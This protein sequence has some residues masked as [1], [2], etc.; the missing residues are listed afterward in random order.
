MFA[1]KIGGVHPLIP[2]SLCSAWPS[3]LLV[4]G[5]DRPGQSET[6]LA[7]RSAAHAKL[8]GQYKKKQQ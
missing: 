5:P 1:L 7:V 8:P 6:E 2:T 4:T 3:P